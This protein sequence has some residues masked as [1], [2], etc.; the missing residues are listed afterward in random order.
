MSHRRKV[1]PFTP[2]QVHPECPHEVTHRL[3]FMA[4]P[5]IFFAI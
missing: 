4:E 2:L 3:R 1:V 5:T